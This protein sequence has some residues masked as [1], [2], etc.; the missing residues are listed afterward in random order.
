MSN[1]KRPVGRRGL[2]KGAAAGAAGFAATPVGGAQ[3]VEQSAT[4]EARGVVEVT[5]NE[6][7]RAQDAR[8]RALRGESQIEFRGSQESCINYGRN[9]SPDWSTCCREESATAM[10]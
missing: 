6:K 5:G 7:P 4:G 8:H 1:S 9:K 2:R 3:P 10:G